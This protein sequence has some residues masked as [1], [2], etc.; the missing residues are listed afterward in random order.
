MKLPATP[1][2]FKSNTSISVK[3]I[4][5]SDI[6]IK[7]IDSLEIVFS[8]P[9]QL[10]SDI[11]L[12][13]RSLGEIPV[14]FWMPDTVAKISDKNFQMPLYSIISE[15]CDTSF[16][17]NL[18]LKIKFKKNLYL[19]DRIS[20][21]KLLKEVQNE[22]LSFYI[23]LQNIEITDDTS[24][25][26]NLIGDVLFSYPGSTP[27]EIEN[28]QI[29]NPFLKYETLNGSLTINDICVKNIRGIQLRNDNFLSLKN[30]IPT[31]TEI[32]AHCNDNGYYT[33]EIFNIS[34]ELIYTNSWISGIKSEK[35][36]RISELID[37]AGF[38]FAVF[39]SP[40]NVEALP[41]SYIK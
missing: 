18:N 30:T 21:G 38:Y 1:Y 19:S 39:K 28:V 32:V 3:V 26:T 22:F 16:K 11:V 27:F 14:K 5:E 23:E 2:I 10:I 17:T 41:I 35:A 6:N 31:G 29:T 8:E 24:N 7:I 12:Q 13:A 37:N 4:F 20:K 15:K 36:F 33:I 25:V 40:G 9:C 34:G